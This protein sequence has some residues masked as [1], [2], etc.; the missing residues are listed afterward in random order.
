MVMWCI[1]GSHTE[2]GNTHERCKDPCEGF[3]SVHGEL[4]DIV[5]TA[6]YPLLALKL[7]ISIY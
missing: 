2:V 7:N 4:P 6:Q 1:I 3:V 5:L